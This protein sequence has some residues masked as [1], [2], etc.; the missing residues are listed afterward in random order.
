MP[1]A[2]VAISDL[3]R[4]DLD[5]I[6]DRVATEAS[7][8]IADFVIARLYETMYRAAERPRIYRK[9]TE[10]SGRP[11]RANVFSYAIF[12]EIEADGGIYVLRIVHARRNLRRIL[13]RRKRRAKKS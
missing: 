1:A 8:E 12:F 13:H 4:E 5:L 3:A 7:A 6:W 11:R 2:R 9:R 10:Y